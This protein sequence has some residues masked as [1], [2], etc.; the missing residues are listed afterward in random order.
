MIL[1]IH[2]NKF[3]ETGSSKKATGHTEHIFHYWSDRSSK[4][5]CEYYY[6][7]AEDAFAIKILSCTWTIFLLMHNLHHRDSGRHISTNRGPMGFILRHHLNLFSWPTST[8]KFN[9]PS[10]LVPFLREF[11]LT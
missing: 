4:S 8:C 2:F 3:F 5:V 7:F 1:K 11:I 6:H 9:F 10:N